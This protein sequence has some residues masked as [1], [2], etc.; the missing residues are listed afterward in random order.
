MHLAG[1]SGNFAA[2]VDE[3][4]IYVDLDD[5]LCETARGFLT[6]LEREFGRRVAFEDI[7]DFD[8]SVSFGLGPADLER[9]FVLAHEHELLAELPPI[10]D[11]IETLGGWVEA[12]HQVAVVTGRPSR[13]LEDSR[14]WLARHR[15]PHHSLTFV[16][17][18]GRAEIDGDE[19]LVPLEALAARSFRFAV[20]DS[21]EMARYL[22][23]TVEIPVFL[24]DRPWNRGAGDGI[25]RCTGWSDVRRLSAE[26]DGS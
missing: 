18:Y 23:D 25:V 7:R 16:D 22:R 24:L 3:R 4:P 2:A 13:T 26:L 20:E 17:K 1:T 15:V 5:V 11:S 21:L 9:L 10:P 14:R 8:L 19:D 6:L 12:G